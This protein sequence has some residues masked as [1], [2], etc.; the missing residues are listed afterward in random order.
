MNKF[1]LNS[2]ANQYLDT[3]NSTVRITILFVIALTS[4]IISIPFFIIIFRYFPNLT[5]NVGIILRIDMI[6]SFLLVYIPVFT[7]LRF[8]GKKIIIGFV[9]SFIL[10][11]ATLQVLNLYSFSQFRDSYF[12]II[13]YVETTPIKLPYFNESKMT[14]RNADDFIKAIDFENPELRTFAV[15]AATNYFKED[16]NYTKYGNIIRYFSVFK[17]IN[18]WDYVSD[19]RGFDYFAMASESAKLLAGDCDDHAI[20]MAASIKAIGGEVRLVHTKNHIY[21]EVKVG[22]LT[23]MTQIYKLIKQNLF[24]KESIGNQIFYRIDAEKNIWMN[25]DYTGHYPGSK[26]LDNTIIGILNL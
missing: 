3:P 24:Y 20:L 14:I 22:K 9:A 8:F 17:T 4:F 15:T 16:N 21:P 25:F 13:N 11:M 10:I 26:Y 18:K 1:R 5:M 19:P 2:L 12:E 6:L 23:D 7:I